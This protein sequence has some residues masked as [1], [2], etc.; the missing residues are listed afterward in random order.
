MEETIK[1]VS[2]LLSK[3]VRECV[4]KRAERASEKRKKRE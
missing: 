1:R 4:G 2:K 3:L